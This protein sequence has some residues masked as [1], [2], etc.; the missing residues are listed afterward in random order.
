VN[1]QSWPAAGDRIRVKGNRDAK[2][3]VTVT[4]VEVMPWGGRI[5]GGCPDYEPEACV[6]QA[7]NPGFFWEHW[8]A[9]S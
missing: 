8:E 7:A 6:A 9:M 4:R 1:D 5:Y 2:H 3:I